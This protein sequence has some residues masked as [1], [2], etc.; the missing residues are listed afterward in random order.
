M[1]TK[2]F[3]G[4][5]YNVLKFSFLSAYV[6]DRDITQNKKEQLLFIKNVIDVQRLRT[7]NMGTVSLIDQ[8]LGLNEGIAIRYEKKSNG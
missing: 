6:R 2:E 5:K 1:S 4:K 7:F 3:N 8:V